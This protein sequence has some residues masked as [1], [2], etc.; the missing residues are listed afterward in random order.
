MMV[1]WLVRVKV[2]GELLSVKA[3]DP[4]FENMGRLVVKVPEYAA[5]LKKA[6]NKDYLKTAHPKITAKAGRYQVQI[7]WDWHGYLAGLDGLEVQ[8]DRGQGW[9]RLAVKPD[10]HVTPTK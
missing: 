4:S 7:E 1:G 8:V 3:S 6:L 5:E 10:C 9:E 2:G